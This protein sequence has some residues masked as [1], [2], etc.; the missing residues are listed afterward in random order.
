[1][2]PEQ[3][4]TSHG[5]PIKPPS[6][7]A[8]ALAA[9]PAPSAMSPEA[10]GMAAP[11]S[12][13]R[14]PEDYITDWYLPEAGFQE[15]YVYPGPL[16]VKDHVRLYAMASALLK[17][18]LEKTQGGYEEFTLREGRR[19]Y[20]G[21]KISTVA[22]SFFALRRLPDVIPTLEVL[23]LEKGITEVLLHPWLKTGGLIMVCGET[24][25]GK[26]TTCAATVRQRMVKHGSFCLTVEDPAEMPLH[27][28][29]GQGRCLQTEVRSGTFADAMR[30]A[31]R[32]YPVVRGSMLYVGE[33]R[34]PETAAEALKVAVNGHLV[35]TTVHSNDLISGIK[36]FTSLAATAMQDS[37]VKSLFSSSFRLALHQ[38]LDEVRS[39]GGR[40]RRRKL[41]ST[42]LIS[43]GLASPVG[44]AVRAGELE[45]LSSVIDQQ[46]RT[47]AS[48]GVHGLINMWK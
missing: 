8:A 19:T 4:K 33:T 41:T 35:L 32:C 3:G 5:S 42:F 14:D 39:H 23:G 45:S 47:L 27:G 20:R 29:H 38:K 28:L 21:H 13:H 9:A 24:G 18:S 46:R 1:M 6:D 10:M 7:L 2:V 48:A 36:R 30:G 11:S 31:M 25:Q 15:G 40:N 43:N 16:M 44:H 26:S 34:D 12:T 22:G 17:R 37:E